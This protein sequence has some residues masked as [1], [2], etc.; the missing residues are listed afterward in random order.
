MSPNTNIHK[1]SFKY[2]P[3]L[4]F[5]VDKIYEGGNHGDISDDVISKL[6]YVGNA[7][8][9]RSKKI[10]GCDEP[11]YIVLYTSNEDIDWPDRLDSETG[12][13]KYYGDNKKPGNKLD[14]KKGNKIL[15]KIFNEQNRYKIPPIFIFSKYPTSKSNRSVKFLG[16]AVPE[17]RNMGKDNSLKAIWRTS[18]EERFINYEAHFT[19]LKVES[20]SRKWLECLIKGD[21]LNKKYAPKSWINYVK[22]GLSENIILKAPKTTEH[23]DKQNQLP[24]SEEDIE[25][26]KLIYNSYK[27]NAYGFESF[28]AE[29][30]GLL[31]NNFSKF[32]VTKRS[33][34]GGFDAF[35]NYKLGHKNHYIK[36]RCL[37]EAKCHNFESKSGIPIKTVSRLISRLRHRDFGIF[38]TTSFVRLSTYKEIIEDSHPI[39]IISGKDIIDILKENHYNTIEAIKKFIENI[40]HP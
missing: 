20:I 26:L 22:N 17:D 2:K 35:G 32:E 19:I 8:G 38:V 5:I 3:D 34:D 9:I 4:E 15:E 37:V 18:N 36:L 14:S 11:A 13:F 27:D 10:S 16:L 23:R 12:K 7:G 29:L 6:M 31:D 1:F 21:S 25:K 30:V 33:K 24:A 40:K 28:A 39:I